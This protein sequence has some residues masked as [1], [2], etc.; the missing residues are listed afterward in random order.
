MKRTFPI[1]SLILACTMGLAVSATTS[2]AITFTAVG[3]GAVTAYFVSETAG[4]GSVIGML[5]NG[6]D[7]G[8][9]GLQNHTSAPGDSLVL[10]TVATGDIITFYLLASEDPAGPPPLD[11]TWY[12]DPTL[13][14][15][16]LEHTLSSPYPGS[17]VP[18]IPA[19]TRVGFEDLPGLGDG[20]FD[21]HV[22]VFTG[23]GLTDPRGVADSGSTLA[24]LGAAMM[25]VVALR[26]KLK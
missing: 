10:G 7:Q 12:S 21:D 5:V 8:I 11:Y 9:T 25:G 24:V 13:N 14:S 1:R 16:S 17:A 15:D 23:P 18:A 6:V 3:S 26:R 19:G 22:F 2:K 20:D 4:F